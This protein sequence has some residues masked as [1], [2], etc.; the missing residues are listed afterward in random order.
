MKFRIE[1]PSQ[2][3]LNKHFYY[4]NGKIYSKYLSTN[5]KID[6]E[7]GVKNKHGYIAMKFKKQTFFAHRIIWCLLNGDL[8]GMDVDHI[9]NVRDDNRI[10][11][12]R[13]LTRS[14]NNENLKT[15]KSNNKT[16]LLGASL[17]KGTNKY[18]AQIKHNNKV[19]HLGLFDTA[20]K[21]HEAY[22]NK[23]REIHIACTI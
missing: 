18:V 6:A 8:K 23:K 10:E 11:N 7:V 2:E 14:Q 17:K 15:A 9:N 13:L 20:E 5:R 1:M 12:L 3:I 4:K 21:A 16:K 19:M 22:I